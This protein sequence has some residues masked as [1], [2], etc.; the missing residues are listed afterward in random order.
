MSVRSTNRMKLLDCVGLGI[1]G[2][3]GTDRSSSAKVFATPRLSWPPGSPI[4]AFACSRPLLCEA[5]AAPDRNGDLSLRPGIAFGRWVGSASVG[6]R[7]R[8]TCSP[9]GR[10]ARFGRNLSSCPRAEPRGPQSRSPSPDRRSRRLNY[11]IRPGALT[12]DFFSGVKRSPSALCRIGLYFV[13]CR[14]FPSLTSGSEA[15]AISARGFA[16]LFACTGSSKFRSPRRDGHP[17]RNVP[18]RSSSRSWGS[19]LLYVSSDRVHGTHPTRA[20]TSRWR[21]RRARSPVR[22]QGGS[23]RWD[24]WSPRSG[25]SPGRAVTPRYLSAGPG[26]AST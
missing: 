7:W 24:R 10:C 26:K 2:I 3:I 21:R 25:A 6:W 19:V 18:L 14:A 5:R 15:R 8:P 13:D 20:A 1:N 9:T 17:S 23:S 4:A 12:S 22:G 11:A 16:A